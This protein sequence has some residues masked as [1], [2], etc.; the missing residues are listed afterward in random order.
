MKQKLKD[1]ENW[2]HLQVHLLVTD[3]IL[4]LLFIYHL[5]MMSIKHINDNGIVGFIIAVAIICYAFTYKKD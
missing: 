1:F 3:F 2:L 5:S 4:P